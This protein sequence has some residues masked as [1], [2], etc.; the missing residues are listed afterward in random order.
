MKISVSHRWDMAPKEAI[1]KQNEL[2][3]KY[4]RQAPLDFGA[5]KFVA[6]ADAAY[7]A[8][9]KKALAAVAL[10]DYFTMELIETA[11]AIVPI[12]F[13]YVPG[14]LS[15]REGPAVVAAF[16]QLEREPDV[17][18]IDGHGIAHPRRFGIASHIG[19]LLDKPTIGVAKTRL[20]GA[21]DEP[22]VR[23]GA[24]SALREKGEEVGT[25]VRTKT[26]VQ[27]VF[28]SVGQ[29]VTLPDAV[30]VVLDC[31]RGY[32]LPEPTRQAHLAANRLKVS[33]GRDKRLMS[34]SWKPAIIK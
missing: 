30:K 17:I 2:R 4:W 8:A 13:P 12:T 29:A 33:A 1:A 24:S 31:C 22:A 19:V 28:V 32:R 23:R 25:V 14:L 5:V 18:L 6:G 11:R 34:I 26:G 7:L 15:W 21:Y 10:F 3:A 16:E 9:A 20:V 27:P